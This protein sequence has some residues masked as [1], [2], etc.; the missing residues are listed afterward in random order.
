MRWEENNIIL[1]YWRDYKVRDGEVIRATMCGLNLSSASTLLAVKRTKNYREPSMAKCH[2][3]CCVTSGLSF[4]IFKVGTIIL[5]Y[6]VVG[7][8]NELI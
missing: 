2:F 1:L 6:R 5:T 4:L 8:L 3:N 7:G